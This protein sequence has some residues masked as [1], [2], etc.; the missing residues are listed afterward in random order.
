MYPFPSVGFIVRSWQAEPKIAK[1]ILLKEIP[2]TIG[3]RWRRKYDGDKKGC[4]GFIMYS[5]VGS[6]NVQ[7]G[8]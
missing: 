4:F 1:R 7:A 6:D 2:P 8:I 5:T 3:T